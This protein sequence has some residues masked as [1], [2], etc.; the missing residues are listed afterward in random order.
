MRSIIRWIIWNHLR[1]VPKRNRPRHSV[2]CCVYSRCDAPRSK[3]SC[4][5][6]M[7][8][9]LTFGELGFC[10]CDMQVSRRMSGDGSSPI[11]TT[12]NQSAWLPMPNRPRSLPLAT[13][14]ARCSSAGST[15]GR[16]CR[17][18]RWRPNGTSKS[19]FCR[20]K[21]WPSVQKS[22][23]AI[24]RSCSISESWDRRSWP[25]TGTPKI[26]FGGT[27]QSLI[28]FWM[29]MVIIRVNKR[30]RS[31]RGSSSR[32]RN[33]ATLKPWRWVR[34]PCP[35][36]RRM[37][38]RALYRLTAG[39]AS[40]S[41]I[42]LTAEDAITIVE[43]EEDTGMAVTAMG[44]ATI[45]TMRCAGGNAMLSREAVV[46]M[47]IPNV[48]EMRTA[49]VRPRTNGR[50]RDRALATEAGEPK[51]ASALQ[52]SRLPSRPRSES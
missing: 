19:R 52:K 46:V 47:A 21:R 30:L 31:T 4:S 3:C 28:A 7:W 11:S 23:F 44:A 17:D 15:T 51:S 2:F 35:D 34:W 37:N 33:T 48:D 38:R 18:F 9:R 49:M 27:M 22:T 8:T 13:S 40:A 20:P 26:R 12:T 50:N 16:C 43:E 32:F 42:K 10:I 29:R 14:C 45:F 25:C 39:V 36:L 6:N 41:P 24:P 1:Q 5:W